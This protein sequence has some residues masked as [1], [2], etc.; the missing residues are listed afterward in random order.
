MCH[1]LKVTPI[2]SEAIKIYN[3]IVIICSDIESLQ[4]PEN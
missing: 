4:N 1:L 3:E 2:I